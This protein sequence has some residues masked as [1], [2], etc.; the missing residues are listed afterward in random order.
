[1]L[2]GCSAVI[3]LLASMLPQEAHRSTGWREYSTLSRSCW[4]FMLLCKRAYRLIPDQRRSM[5]L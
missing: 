4:L 2:H 3:G 1:M 5:G